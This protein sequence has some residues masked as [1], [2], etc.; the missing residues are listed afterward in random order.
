[1]SQECGNP[2]Q[3]SFQA[4]GNNE[5]FNKQGCDVNNHLEEEKKVNPALLYTLILK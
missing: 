1:M 2:K 3:G 4:T 5:L